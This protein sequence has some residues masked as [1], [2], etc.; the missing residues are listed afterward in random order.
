MKLYIKQHVF[1]LGE[2]FEVR[3]S[4]QNVVFYVEGSFFRIPKM[5]TIYDNTG[6]QVAVIERQMLRMFS[7][8]DINAVDYETITLRREFSFMR[9]SYSLVGIDW[10][11]RGN[12][13]SHNYDLVHGSQI[14][15]SMSKHWF[16]WEDSYE[17]DVLDDKDALVALC[18][19]I[20]IDNEIKRDS[21]D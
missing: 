10:Y 9:Q 21:S 14:I 5:F 16:T 12:F 11:L 3:D 15:M 17:L 13:M 19:A 8:Y 4:N 20:C 6:N 1:T 7:H 18:I 2:R